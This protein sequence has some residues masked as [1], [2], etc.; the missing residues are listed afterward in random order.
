MTEPVVRPATN[1]DLLAIAELDRECF[2]NPWSLELYRQELHRPFARLV[3][4]ERDGALLGLSCSW[5]VG[6][7]AHLLR[8]ATRAAVRRQGLGRR[9]LESVLAHVREAGCAVLLLEVAAAN[10]P[11]RALYER[12][13]FE[14]LAVRKAYYRE[15][16]DD[17]VVMQRRLSR[18]VTPP[19]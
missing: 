16:P 2:G 19:R 1:A 15:P 9:L 5:V 11:A 12:F 6:D 13:G 17:A 14:Q 3:V 8:I 10:L 7:E 4:M 18:S